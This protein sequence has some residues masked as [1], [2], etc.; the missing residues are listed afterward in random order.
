MWR[1][2]EGGGD[3]VLNTWQ[4]FTIGLIDFLLCMLVCLSVPLFRCVFAH[5][6]GTGTHSIGGHQCW[7]G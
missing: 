4:T 1:A 5:D 6:V 3:V 2:M 7:I